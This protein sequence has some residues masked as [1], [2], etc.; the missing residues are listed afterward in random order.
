MPPSESSNVFVSARALTFAAYACFVP[1]GIA[2]VLLGPLLPTLSA[3][4]SLNYSQAGALFTVQYLASTDR[5]GATIDL[6]DLRT[7]RRA[8]PRTVRSASS[9]K[10]R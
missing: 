1:I 3:R 9:G 8:P 4:W 6:N 2:N 5:Y 7:T 10:G